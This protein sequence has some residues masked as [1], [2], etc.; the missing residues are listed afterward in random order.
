MKSY[1]TKLQDLHT[2]KHLLFWQPLLCDEKGEG[3]VS[4]RLCS[5]VIRVEGCKRQ[6][7]SA[8]SPRWSVY[9]LPQS[10]FCLLTVPLPCP[11]LAPLLTQLLDGAHLPMPHI[12]TSELR[13][14][15]GVCTTL[16]IFTVFFSYYLLLIFTHFLALTLLLCTVLALL[17]V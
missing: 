16:L 14:T 8:G 12:F 11:F 3:V 1:K 7:Q 15:S 17:L 13:G 4:V 5:S 2:M 9:S 6:G 10:T